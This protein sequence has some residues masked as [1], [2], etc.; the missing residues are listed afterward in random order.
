MVK[1]RRDFQLEGGSNYRYVNA[2]MLEARFRGYDKWWHDGGLAYIP[3]E[4]YIGFTEFMNS[5]VD[6]LIE[7]FP[8]EFT[9]KEE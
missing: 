6:W 5:I 9:D 2:L 7:N 8:D 3:E 1:L 4:H